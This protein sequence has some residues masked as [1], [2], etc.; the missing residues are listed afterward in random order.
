MTKNGTD[1]RK[2][3]LDT[4][5]D[6]FLLKSLDYDGKFEKGEATKCWRYEFE[7]HKGQH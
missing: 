4:Y 1:Q 3:Y 5:V 7:I 6:F 2:L